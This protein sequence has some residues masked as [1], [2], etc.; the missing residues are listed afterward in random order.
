MTFREV[1]AALAA[2]WTCNQPLKADSAVEPATVDEMA[3]LRAWLEHAT[4]IRG[5]ERRPVLRPAP[6]VLVAGSPL[7]RIHW[8]TELQAVH[9]DLER[10]PNYY[11]V[12]RE[13][14]VEYARGQPAPDLHPFMITA[15]ARRPLLLADV[16]AYE[17]FTV[18]EAGGDLGDGGRIGP[19]A[20]LKMD[21]R[22]RGDP[23]GVQRWLAW[24]AAC[25]FQPADTIL[26]GIW[27]NDGHDVLVA[28]SSAVLEVTISPYLS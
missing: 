10:R 2:P 16:A 14:A 28:R 8:Q 6:H 24:E 5:G 26:D 3:A 13:V 20:T 25:G 15:R 17:V 11:G 27:D 19:F 21:P 23:I 7:Y 22:F 1:L 18:I 4:C 12:T 9:H